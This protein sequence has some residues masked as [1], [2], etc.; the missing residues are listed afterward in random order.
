MVMDV[1]IY[2][3]QDVGLQT[4]WLEEKGGS[5]VSSL[6][7]TVMSYRISGNMTETDQNGR[8]IDCRL[9]VSFC[10]ARI[11]VLYLCLAN[12]G[13]VGPKESPFG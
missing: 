7:S 13:K 5:S 3:V 8:E 4:V 9:L 11:V 6:L 1:G 2:Y 10:N 12:Y